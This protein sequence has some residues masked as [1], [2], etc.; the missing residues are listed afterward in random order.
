MQVIYEV[1]HTGPHLTRIVFPFIPVIPQEN[2]QL[3]T[4]VDSLTIMDGHSNI[5]QGHEMQ[6]L[7]LN[8]GIDLAG[9]VRFLVDCKDHLIVHILQIRPEGIQRDV[10]LI[11]LL[12]HLFYFV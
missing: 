6:V 5:Q 8:E 10:M 3:L 12:H 1:H 9:G 2:I 11:V 7:I 4:T